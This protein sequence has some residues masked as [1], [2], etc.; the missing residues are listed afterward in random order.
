[1]RKLPFLLLVPVALYAQEPSLNFQVKFLRI[2]MSSCGQ[3]GLDCPDAAMKAKLEGVG[4]NV[5]PTF[6]LALASSEDEVKSLKKAGKL[7]VVTNSAWL[8]AGAGVAVTS[9][10]GKPQIRLDAAN[11]KASGVTLSDTI[12]KMSNGN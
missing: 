11:I 1:M 2:L 4:L 12:I 5:A 6:K 10:D 7:V 3:Y 8:A 9:V